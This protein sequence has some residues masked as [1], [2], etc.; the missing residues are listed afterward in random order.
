MFLNIYNR[1]ALFV[2]MIR[3]ARNSTRKGMHYHTTTVR[4]KKQLIRQINNILQQNPH[5]TPLAPCKR[6]VRKNSE[7][8][9]YIYTYLGYYEKRKNYCNL[10]KAKSNLPG[11]GNKRSI[12]RQQL[13]KQV[14]VLFNY[15]GC[16]LMIPMGLNDVVIY[17]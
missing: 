5:L 16:G 6:I 10:Q 7:P 2:L 12:I 4:Q 13:F 9:S 17:L 8:R 15:Y 3:R 1:L 11:Q 14:D